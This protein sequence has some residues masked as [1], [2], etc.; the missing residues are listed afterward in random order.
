[1]RLSLPALAL[2][3]MLA[4]AACSTDRPL[5]VAA[6]PVATLAPASDGPLQ[7]GQRQAHFSA[8]PDRLFSAARAA[9]SAP[10]QV[11]TEP[12]PGLLRCETLPTPD[13]AATLILAY[14][15]TVEALPLYVVSFSAAPDTAGYLVTADSYVAV[16]QTDGTLREIRLPDPAVEASL[17]DLLVAAGGDPI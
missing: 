6:L 2:P 7:P 17:V 10:G 5:A 8:Y 14:G 12:A 9:C 15:G 16:P 1:M 11:P 4:L 13:I 3:L